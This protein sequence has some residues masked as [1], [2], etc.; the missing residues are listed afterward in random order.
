MGTATYLTCG[1]CFT[2]RH[3][4]GDSWDP[5]TG[6]ESFGLPSIYVCVCVSAGVRAGVFA[7]VL[8]L[9]WF[10]GE[11]KGHP[12]PIWVRLKIKQEGL[13]RFW[14][15]FPLIRVPFW[16]RFFEPQ[17]FWVA[18]Q[19]PSLTHI[20]IPLQLKALSTCTSV[21]NAPWTIHCI[22]CAKPASRRGKAACEPS[23]SFQVHVFL[24]VREMQGMN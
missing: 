24:L 5:S 9:G 7:L 18:V 6:C 20:H 10:A 22:K 8:S 4:K 13:R 17:P 15:M 1:L 21:T 12:D 14:S 3:D 23:L 2:Q 11:P 19:S 16:Y